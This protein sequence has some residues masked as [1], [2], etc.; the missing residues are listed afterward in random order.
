MRA[1]ED[2]DATPAVFSSSRVIADLHRTVGGDSGNDTTVAA[3]EAVTGAGIDVHIVW[4]LQLFQYRFQAPPLSSEDPIAAP[5]PG[6]DGTDAGQRARIFWHLPIEHG[7]YADWRA[8][9]IEQRKTAPHAETN[10]ADTRGIDPRMCR[11]PFA[12]R[13]EGGERLT[14]AVAQAG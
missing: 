13:V 10:D 6:D 9:R 12:R 2:F 7:A 14:F 1:E 5:I 11:Q 3:H 4:H 8:Y